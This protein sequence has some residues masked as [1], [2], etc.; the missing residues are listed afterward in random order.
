MTR[1]SQPE[2]ATL[3]RLLDEVLELPAEAR[4]AWLA[5]RRRS[6]PELADQLV[7][8]VNREGQLERDGFLGEGQSPALP[9]VSTLAGQSLGAYILER[10]LGQGGM[11]SV[12]LARRND[13]R[14]EGVAA[15]KFL[16]LAVA[17][18]AGE[19]RFRREGSVL[20]RLTHPNIARLL[21]AGVTP[22]GQPYL[23]LEH[24]DGLPLDAWCDAHR[25]PIEG[26]LR[27]FE[28]VLAAV[29]H[30]HDNFV[31]HRD[32]KPANILVT[33]DGTVKLLDFGIAK[34]LEEGGRAPSPLT[35]SHE[36]VLTFE[37]AAPEQ[38]RGDPI[39]AATDVYSLGV[40]LYQLLAGR[41]PTG[42]EAHTPA[43]HVVAILNTDPGQ[44]SRAV[45]PSAALS[46]Q[47]AERL[48]AARAAS[49]DKLS[50]IFAG[51][52]DNILARA[53]RKNSA[54]RYPTVRAFAD[55]IEHY[56]AN[57]PVSARP[58]AWSYRTGKF[59]RRHR[60]GVASAAVVLLILIGATVM[61]A[62]QARE[63][64]RQRDGALREVRRQQAMN[65]VQKV[66]AGD[67]RGPDGRQLLPAERIGLALRVLKGGFRTEPWL[68][69]EVMADLSGNFYENGDRE[70]QRS[71]LAQAQRMARDDHLLPQLALASCL[72]VYSFAYDDVF[73]SAAT[74]LAEAKSAM[75]QSRDLPGEIEIAC[76]DAEGQLLVE[77]GEPDSAIP[78]LTRAVQRLDAEAGASAPL[79][80]DRPQLLNDLAQA[81]R[82]AGRIREA[83]EYQRGLI[84]DLDAA[85]YATTEVLP[86]A[87]S[88][89]IAS[90]KDLG[91]VATAESLAA[92][93]VREQEAVNGA[94]QASAFMG[95][96]LGIGH[97]R[98]ERLDSADFWIARAM[99][100]TT[101][102]AGG[103][104][105]WIPPTLAQLRLDQHRP[106]E[107]GGFI[108]RIPHASRAHEMLIDLYQAR[109]HR[110]ERD[111]AGAPLLLE[112]A[113][114]KNSGT[115]PR[116]PPDL[117]LPLIF[118]AQWRLEDRDPH[119]ADSL[120]RRA[121]EAAAVD[122][123]AL[124][125]SAF[126]GRAELIL[127]EAMARENDSAGARTAA[128]RA[129]VA[130]SHGFSADHPRTLQAIALRDS[131]T[132]K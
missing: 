55:D 58:D 128:E 129:I 34:L 43:E 42:A 18:P 93:V 86:N 82:A 36:A 92:G 130:L 97:L 16:S 69:A 121:R 30:A 131:L 96:T 13:G 116:L 32:I 91:E 48:A 119:G 53:L 60:V 57:E 99:R 109:K 17:G 10:P 9:P 2:W 51:D 11:G 67:A 68:V 112:N 7:E 123:L 66:L 76:L 88:F 104:S 124:T 71:I 81:L 120:A 19:A 78:L 118:A 31:V 125:R 107:A 44:L 108:A 54:E 47:A 56:L 40:V 106:Q 6:H 1:F 65:S 63:A 52:L 127:A 35:G 94:G 122:S 27:L 101:E 114:R 72:R 25:L 111:S 26:R 90:L 89:L 115:G 46:R 3:S 117:A 95:F 105:Y 98:L 103:I 102:G 49:P 4:P 75:A 77:K 61:T 14:F 113:I 24:V 23:V 70:T 79:T 28:Q 85:G 100:D 84:R 64:R 74:D 87:L 12:W 22:A 45:T 33:E 20:A 38:I 21:D 41:H 83:S 126:V 8:L 59:I 50:R 5:E 110:E 132:R 62:L 37:Y 39:S 29:A 15:I 80:T 73:D